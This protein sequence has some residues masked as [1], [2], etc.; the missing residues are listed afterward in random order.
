MPQNVSAKSSASEAQRTASSAV[1]TTP[2]SNNVQAAKGNPATN[3]DA[4]RKS[5][6]TFSG[7]YSKNCLNGTRCLTGYEVY[8]STT[9]HALTADWLNPAKA[10][11]L[12][13]ANSGTRTYTAGDTGGNVVPTRADD[14]RDNSYTIYDSTLSDATIY[15]Y[16]IRA[17]DN[18]PLEPDGGPFNSSL[19]VISPNTIGSGWDTTP[20]NSKP[21]V[22]AVELAIK[23]K[24]TYP[25]ADKVRNVLTWIVPNAPLRKKQSYETCSVE[26][27]IGGVQYCN[28][29]GKYEVHREMDDMN[30]NITD[31]KVADITDFQT[32]IYTDEADKVFQDFKFRYYI[33][34][35]DN[36]DPIFKYQNGTV[37]NP[38]PD[39][40]TNYSNRTEKLYATDSIIPANSSPCLP[41]RGPAELFSLL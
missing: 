6:I 33:I 17:I 8:R 4:G 16:K 11:K 38:G 12:K 39:Q 18:T 19:S 1:P 9:N 30:G 26:Q 29:F 32:N 5:T 13:L 10:T 41:F 36:A 2:T 14:D 20:D 31:V 3:A 22:T 7:S 15:F 40:N 23:I 24:D 34:V 21:E 25:K 28:D 27:T 37:V 35:V